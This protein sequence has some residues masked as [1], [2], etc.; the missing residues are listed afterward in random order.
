MKFPLWWFFDRSPIIFIVLVSYTNICVDIGFFSYLQHLGMYS[1]AS[2]QR[3]IAFIEE[4]IYGS[5]TLQLSGLGMTKF[6]G[7]RITGKIIRIVKG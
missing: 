3:S 2:L 6:T 4:R 1:S 5:V 7:F